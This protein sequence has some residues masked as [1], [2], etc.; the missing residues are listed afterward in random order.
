[1]QIVTLYYILFKRRRNY[2]C[3]LIFMFLF[4][5]SSKTASQSSIF[6]LTKRVFTL[7]ELVVVIAII[8]I[9]A[10]IIAP[11][12]FRAIEKAKVAEI[13]GDFK[14]YKSSIYALYADTGK[15]I[16]RGGVWAPGEFDNYTSILLRDPGNSFSGKSWW[17]GPYVGWNGPYINKVKPKSPWMGRY[18]IESWQNF[19]NGSARELW[20]DFEDYCYP[21]GP[22]KCAMPTSSALRLDRLIDDGNLATGSVERGKESGKQTANDVAWILVWDA[23]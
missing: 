15:W 6:I 1:M 14:T 8:A 20:L 4:P 12:A 7:I 10:A 17:N 18:S 22:S 19:G 2:Y 16:I 3:L 11:N 9:L 23:F 13:I 5:F 21:S